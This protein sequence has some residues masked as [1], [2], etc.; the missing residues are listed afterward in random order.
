MDI[1]RM[2]RVHKL[3][4]SESTGS[5]AELGEKFGVKDRQ[6]EYYIAEF[7]F[8]EAKIKYSR[9]RKTYFYEEPYDF[10]DEL[11][12]GLL[13]RDVNKKKLLTLLK[14]YWNKKDDADK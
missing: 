14:D 8:Y 1:E 12:I 6:A 4:Q 11:S 2:Y 3:I 5:P 10:F 7:R 9:K 13:D